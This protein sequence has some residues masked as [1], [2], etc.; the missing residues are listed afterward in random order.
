MQLS[1][2]KLAGMFMVRYSL[3]VSGILEFEPNRL[4]QVYGFLA[5]AGKNL[6]EISENIHKNTG[7][8]WL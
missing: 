7:G 5:R 6:H 8:L 2:S 4:C 3:S 1:G